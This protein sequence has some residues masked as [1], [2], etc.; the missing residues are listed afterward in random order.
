MTIFSFKQLL[1]HLA[2]QLRLQVRHPCPSAFPHQCCLEINEGWDFH[3]PPTHGKSCANTTIH[4]RSEVGTMTFTP[5]SLQMPAIV[6]SIGVAR[7]VVICGSVVSQRIKRLVDFMTIFS[8]SNF[9]IISFTTASSSPSTL[10]SDI[11]AQA[12]STKSIAISALLPSS[13][14]CWSP[15]VLKC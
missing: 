4:L 8:S 10:F 5:T 1:D 12:C 3:A 7:R 6:L 9:L 14:K 13:V 11:F 15:F 2:Q